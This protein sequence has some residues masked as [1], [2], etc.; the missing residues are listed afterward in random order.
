MYYSIG[1][2]L[3]PTSLGDDVDDAFWLEVFRRVLVS[4]AYKPKDWN[5]IAKVIPIFA[6]GIAIGIATTS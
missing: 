1:P 5:K 3:D 2:G 4:D 6:I